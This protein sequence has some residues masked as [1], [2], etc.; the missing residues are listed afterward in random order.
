MY[1]YPPTNL[2]NLCS[3]TYEDCDVLVESKPALVLIE[4]A[5]AL[6]L[7]NALNLVR[8]H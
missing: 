4:Q 8:L 5:L 2:I 1:I 3:I 6:M 7:V